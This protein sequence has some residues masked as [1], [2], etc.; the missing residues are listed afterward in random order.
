MLENTNYKSKK[1]SIALF[2]TQNIM[3]MRLAKLYQ[4]K[5]AEFENDIEIFILALVF[6]LRL[7]LEISLCFFN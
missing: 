1:R 3:E 7:W 2:N 4:F 5:A 6:E